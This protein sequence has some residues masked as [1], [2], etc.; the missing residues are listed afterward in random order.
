MKQEE[1]KPGLNTP[2]WAVMLNVALICVCLV[3]VVLFSPLLQSEWRF[4]G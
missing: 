4:V 2:K 1:S 3:L